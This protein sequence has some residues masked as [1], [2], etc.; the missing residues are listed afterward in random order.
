MTD[1]T[2]MLDVDVTA[3]RAGVPIGRAV[4]LAVVVD[5]RA[6][7]DA[8]GGPRPALSVTFVLDSSGSMQGDP[9]RQVKD[10]VERLI[11][12]L[13]PTDEV[14][15][16]AFADNPVVVADRA[17]LTPTHKAALKRR[18]QGVQARGGT[19]MTAGLRSGATALGARSENQRQVL[20]LLTDGAPTDGASKES[21]GAIAQELRPDISTTTMGY[22]PNH[23]ADLLDGVAKAGGGQYWYIPDPQ[24]AQVEFARALGAQ[25][26]VVVDGVELVL[27]P[28][29]GTEIL[30]VLDAGKVRVS[31]NGL[32][33]P[34][35][36]LRAEQLHTTIVRL[37]IDAR[38]EAGR[39]KPLAVQVRYRKAGQ[40]VVQ[41][42]DTG[43]AVDV[44]HGEP[45]INVEATRKVA[46]ANA[47]VKRAEARHHADQG[48]FDAAAVVLRA[49]VKE[50][51]AL[52]GY[53][54]MDGSPVSEAVEQLLD[55][56]QA[57]ETRPSAQ[58]YMEFRSTNL[59][60]D[61]GQG[62][63][64]SAD[65]KAQSA[66]SR[67]LMAGVVDQVVVGDI[68]VRHKGRADV[69]IPLAG[70]LT[71]GRV[72]GND[73]V[74]P[75]GN[76]S[77]RHT[78]IAARDGRVIV[79]DLK[80]TNGTYINGARVSTPQVIGPDDKIVIGDSTLTFEPKK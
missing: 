50:L 26:D 34:R 4:E 22:G 12:L 17:P 65:V 27:L 14:A 55:E 44:V 21:L 46:L 25:G 67:A 3:E 69:V 24:E 15:V 28:A 30:E 75:F 11:D 20:L 80:A 77:K 68:V 45:A 2:K 36:D 60:V 8:V 7:G 37:R 56:I 38:S 13:S 5:L 39:L 74:L 6:A 35:P 53:A 62:S 71:I 33:V 31:A 1:T 78:R 18:L 19:G 64:H 42:I 63:R 43:L 10:S 40:S 58:E 72:E 70:E 23:N 61:I 57:Y 59:Q 49:L 76:V 16:V 29:E 9:I 79:V 73:I 32:V 47:E 51:E 48:H 54:K 52:P 66:T 41:T